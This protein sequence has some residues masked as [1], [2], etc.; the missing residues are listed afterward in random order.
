MLIYMLLYD[1]VYPRYI[2]NMTIIYF[3]LIVGGVKKAWQD[4]WEYVVEG[5][6]M[7]RKWERSLVGK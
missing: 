1:I 2:E 5:R 7:Y 6:R 4:Q 3:H